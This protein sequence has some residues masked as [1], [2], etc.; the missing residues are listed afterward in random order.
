MKEADTSVPRAPK[1]I[2]LSDKDIARFWAKVDKEGPLPDQTNPHYAGLD[3][4]WVWTAGGD[5][6]GYGHLKAQQKT[7]KAPRVAWTLTHGQIPHD[8]T[9]HGICVCHKCDNPSCVNPSHLFLGTIGEDNR[10]KAVKGRGNSP[11]GDKHGSRTHPESVLRGEARSGAKLTADK[12]L[13]IRALYAAGGISQHKLAARFGVA[14]GII[15]RIIRRKKW[16]HV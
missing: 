6:H 4:C 11:M 1:E 9:H 8:G 10:D 3:R 5:Y 7:F 12:V 15:W 14:Q 16:A 13:L 2:N